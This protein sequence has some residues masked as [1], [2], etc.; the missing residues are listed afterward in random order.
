MSQSPTDNP[1]DEPIEHD[2]PV[3]ATAQLLPR[4]EF[5]AL[6]LTDNAPRFDDGAVGLYR[7]TDPN[8]PP[9]IDADNDWQAVQCFLR[10]KTLSGSGHTVRAYEKECLR[11]FLW[12]RFFAFKP[13]SSLTREDAQNY[14]HFLRSPSRAF[15]LQTGSTYRP[16][17]MLLP[18]GRINPAWRPFRKKGLSEG[19]VRTAIAAL[20]SLSK[21]LVN[22]DYL[23]ASPFTLGGLAKR[24]KN[25]TPSVRKKVLRE[26]AKAA[27]DAAID[28]L[29]DNTEAQRKRSL[30]RRYVFDLFYYLGLRMDEAIN[31]RMSGFHIV[32]KRCWFRALGKGKKI[33]SVPVP[34]A[35]LQT[36]ADYRLTHDLEPPFPTP[37]EETPLVARVDGTKSLKDTQLRRLIVGVFRAGADQLERALDGQADAEAIDA[38][39]VLRHATPHWLRHT[40]G[41]DLFNA[42][43]DPRHI[44]EN[45]G[46]SSMDTTLIYNENEDAARHEDTQ[47]RTQASTPPA[48]E[49]PAVD[50][51]G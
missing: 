29:P 46:H 45:M 26:R 35:L 36:L 31:A 25:R 42:G 5:E 49:P 40:Y 30:R 23:R 7:N 2:D 3:S 13:F 41:T 19:S 33:R 48:S 32:N 37:D 47:K 27:I 50:A 14:Q 34:D 51:S 11:L 39:D 18:N 20:K 21:F 38:L 24:D 43:V 17:P 10:D 6:I 15:V 4:G 28:A 44:Q 8:R 16:A 12:C 1:P 22:A 9:L